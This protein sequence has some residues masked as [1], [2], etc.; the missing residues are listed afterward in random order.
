MQD[1]RPMTVSEETVKKAEK[2][3]RPLRRAF[4]WITLSSELDQART[5]EQKS[6]VQRLFITR[7]ERAARTADR[8]LDSPQGLDREPELALE[9]Y[10][11]AA[12][13]LGRAAH[14]EAAADTPLTELVAPDPE[15]NP[16]LVRG[17][18]AVAGLLAEPFYSRCERPREE[19]EGRAR[20]AQRWLAAVLLA[21]RQRFWSASNLRFRR[22]LRV[23]AL[24]TVLLG[25]LIGTAS[26][27]V[28]QARGPDL[29]ANRPWRASSSM[30]ECNPA[31]NQCGGAATR[32][33]FHTREEPNPWVEIEL[34]GVRRVGRVE[35]DNR[36]D[37]GGD[38][39]VPLI[40]ELSTDGK[41]YRPVA[42][43]AQRFSSWTA[44]FTPTDARYVRLRVPRT[45]MLHLER[46]SVRK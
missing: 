10:A 30:F 9:L 7:A 44:T 40:V 45:T 33:F 27:A 12:Y 28:Y 1:G 31:A 42:E 38:R 11:E 46:V 5:H 36:S 37:D 2:A 13:W 17:D 26:L 6:A 23:G 19:C 22:A 43:R 41:S 8:L 21:A 29:A 3:P 32:I 18:E 4:D 34:E 35:V 24:F 16:W 20:D 15:T 25:L 39:A 14:P